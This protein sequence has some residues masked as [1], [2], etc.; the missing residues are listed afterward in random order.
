[1][2]FRHLVYLVVKLAHDY[3]RADMK[4]STF[5]PPNKVTRQC[6]VQSLCQFFLSN[7]RFLR[8]DRKTQT[9]K[10]VDNARFYVTELFSQHNVKIF[11]KRNDL[12]SKFIHLTP[13]QHQWQQPWHLTEPCLDFDTTTT[14]TTT[15]TGKQIHGSLLDKPHDETQTGNTT[16]MPLCD[17]LPDEVE[18]QT[19]RKDDGMEVDGV[20]DC[21]RTMT[22][23][24][25]L[26]EGP[27]PRSRGS[28]KDIHKE[29]EL[30]DELLD[31]E[32]HEHEHEHEQ[33]QEQEQETTRQ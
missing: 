18:E 25:N 12:P 7:W 1:M 19:G 9:Y 21:I 6:I 16:G 26:L 5:D 15:T 22:T 28:P 33:E 17:V 32:E 30:H 13:S 11:R 10:Q 8:K 23:T 31:E 29:E 14:T 2:A 20:E 3:Y 24:P 27:T 4:R